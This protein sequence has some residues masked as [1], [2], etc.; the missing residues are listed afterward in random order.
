MRFTS[1]V[2][3]VDKIKTK[4]LC[5]RFKLDLIN[6]HLSK[7]RRK[8]MYKIHEIY[9]LDDDDSLAQHINCYS[10]YIIENQPL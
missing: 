3:L 2:H 4:D 8:L 10:D 5:D 9:C 1:D 6:V 7:L